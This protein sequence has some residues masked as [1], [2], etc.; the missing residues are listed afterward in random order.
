MRPILLLSCKDVAT[1]SLYLYLK[2]DAVNTDSCSDYVT[3]YLAHQSN[4][5]TTNVEKTKKLTMSTKSLCPATILI[6]LNLH[7]HLLL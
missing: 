4:G 6:S 1:C 7:S 3:A 2:K 5:L